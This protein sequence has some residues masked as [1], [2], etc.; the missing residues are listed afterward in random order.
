MYEQNI[1]ELACA[2]LLVAI[3]DFFKGVETR[4]K[5]LKDLRS[6]WMDYLTDG[7]SI[8]LAHE[9]ETNPEQI[10]TRYKLVEG[11]VQNV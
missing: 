5:I 3:K 11:R 10:R 1:R 2:T 9:L 4:H 8:K 7:L 6:E